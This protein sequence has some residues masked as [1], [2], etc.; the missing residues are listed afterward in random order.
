M[1]SFS[2]YDSEW[3][4]TLMKSEFEYVFVESDIT[5]EG[6]EPSYCND[7]PLD[8]NFALHW[9]RKATVALQKYQ[10]VYESISPTSITELNQFFEETAK[11]IF[12]VIRKPKKIE[13]DLDSFSTTDELTIFLINQITNF[14]EIEP[15]FSRVQEIVNE[16]NEARKQLFLKI[17]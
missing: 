3:F 17:S 4:V 8:F 15:K 7:I 2:D 16:L 12:E 13:V 1:S 9:I 6:I 14:S 10:E 11:A 5:I